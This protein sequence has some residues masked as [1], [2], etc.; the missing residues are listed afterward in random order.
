MTTFQ[1]FKLL[2]LVLLATSSCESEK[3]NVEDTITVRNAHM[4]AFNRKE[5]FCILFGG[6]NEKAVLNDT[7]VL[8]DTI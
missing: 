5:G 3:T 8:K 7:W 6:A 1:Y 4:M 2:L